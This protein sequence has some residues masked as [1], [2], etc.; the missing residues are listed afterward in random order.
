MAMKAMKATKAPRAA[1]A[2]APPKAMK[3]QRA[4]KAAAPPKA[5]KALTAMKAMKAAKVAPY[6]SITGAA[7]ES[8]TVMVDTRGV[9]EVA[10]H[11][12]SSADGHLTWWYDK[13]FA[14]VE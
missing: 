9:V 5:M 3:A 14:P 11:I 1:K 13:R 6:Q 4:A 10:F 7:G 12:S 2:A 8:A